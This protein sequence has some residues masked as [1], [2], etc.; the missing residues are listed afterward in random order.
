MI[1]AGDAISGLIALIA[2]YLPRM[3]SSAHNTNQRKTTKPLIRNE[4][5]GFVVYGSIWKVREIYFTLP[6]GW[7]APFQAKMPPG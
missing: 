1:D 2:T 4:I 6:M 7:P 5:R 3:S